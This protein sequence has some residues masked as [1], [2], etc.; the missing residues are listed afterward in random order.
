MIHQKIVQALSQ[1]THK[2]EEIP[3]WAARQYQT[4]YYTYNFGYVQD[5]NSF[6]TQKPLFGV[7]IE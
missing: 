4:K 6:G 3:T 2:S 1:N 7:L 5:H